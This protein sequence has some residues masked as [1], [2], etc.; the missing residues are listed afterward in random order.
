MM[1][2]TSLVP[3]IISICCKNSKIRKHKKIIVS[4]NKLVCLLQI[5]KTNEVSA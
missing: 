3:F 4:Q 5:I 2:T 1:S